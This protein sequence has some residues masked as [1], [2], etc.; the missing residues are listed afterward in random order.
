MSGDDGYYSGIYYTLENGIMES[1]TYYA[2]EKYNSDGNPLCKICGT[3]MDEPND[4]MI[5]DDCH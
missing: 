2:P 3:A 1:F 5:C 4:Y